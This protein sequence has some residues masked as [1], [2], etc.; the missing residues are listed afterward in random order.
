MVIE[1]TIDEI[2][3]MIDSVAGDITETKSKDEY[4]IAMSVVSDFK[5]VFAEEV[6][7][8]VESYMFNRLGRGEEK[9]NV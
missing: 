3:E 4:P 9:S 6:L 1:F 7:R 2:K 8:Q 5:M